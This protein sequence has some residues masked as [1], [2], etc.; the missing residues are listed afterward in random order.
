MNRGTLPG[1]GPDEQIFAIGDIHGQAVTLEKALRRI[2][3][4]PRTGKPSHLVYTG[5]IIDRGDENLRCIDLVMNSAKIAG[6]DKVTLL[7][8]NHEIM[9]LQS[10]VKDADQRFNMEFWARNGGFS[11]IEEVDKDLV[12]RSIPQIGDT[13]KERLAGFISLLEN[14]PNSL[15]AGDLVFVHAGLMAGCDIDD[16]LSQDRFHSKA[17]TY[18][19]HWAWTRREFL[20]NKDGW[21]P[22]GHVV[23][24]H[25]HTPQNNNQKI[26][27]AF[28]GAF[29]DRV[30]DSRRI[31]LD[32]GAT[33]MGQVG[34]LNVTGNTYQIEV[35]QEHP[36]NPAF[37]TCEPPVAGSSDYLPSLG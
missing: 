7:P 31:C 33:R 3:V 22:L 16:F 29:L 30:E 28:T 5:D 6:V 11:V 8:G 24:V 10:L 35:V 37:E 27:P 21:D 18:S 12:K 25:G 17:N 15:R 14:S 36:F 1:Y 23:V 26:D 19:E 9:F 32:A 13:L 34:L 4:T 20:A 2:A